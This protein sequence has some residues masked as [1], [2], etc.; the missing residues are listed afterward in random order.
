VSSSTIKFA[1]PYTFTF[2]NDFTVSADAEVI[3]TST[4]TRDLD[5]WVQTLKIE[6]VP[7][8]LPL[9]GAATAIGWSRRICK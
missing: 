3:V 1:N 9:F 8:P 2:N 5:Y 7:G 6:A 4:F